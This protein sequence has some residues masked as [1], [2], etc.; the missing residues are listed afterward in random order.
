MILKFETTIQEIKSLIIG[1]VKIRKLIYNTKLGVDPLAGDDPGEAGMGERITLLPQSEYLVKE[2]ISCIVAISGWSVSRIK[3][4]E[5]QSH[6]ITVAVACS[7]DAW[8]VTTEEQE[9]LRALMIANEI[10]ELCHSRKFSNAMKL[11][12]KDIILKKSTD[13]NSS[14]SGYT[15]IFESIDREENSREINDY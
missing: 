2:D 14:M 12:L 5:T 6:V 13:D 8:V 3:I 15:C 11:T 1:D 10:V 9:R 4:N 7:N